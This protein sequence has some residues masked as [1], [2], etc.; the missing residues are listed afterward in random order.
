MQSTLLEAA[1]AY[2]G[3]GLSVIPIRADGSKGPACSA[4]KPYQ[5]RR[6]TAEELPELFAGDVGIGILGGAVSGN[7]E[8]LDFDK[9]GVFEEWRELVEV[10][11]PGLGAVVDALP[12]VSTP[13]D[14]THLYLRCASIEGNLKLAR[15]REPF[16]DCTG[17]SKLELIETR[18]TGG[19]VVAPPSPA[20]CHKANKPYRWVGGAKLTQIP[21][22]TPAQ[23]EAFLKAARYFNEQEEEQPK[24]EKPA[25]AE[26][27]R[28]GL[29]PGDDYNRRASWVDILTGA[30]ATV[31][32]ERGDV[33][34][35]RRPGKTDRGMSAT[36]GKC[37]G[38]S[39]ND[40]LYV[41]S[42]NWPPFEAERTY[43][44]FAAFA[45]LHHGGDF[46]EAARDLGRQGY[47]EPPRAKSN[48]P[49][50]EGN[51]PPPPTDCDCPPW[52]HAENDNAAG[53]EQAAEVTTVSPDAMA[54]VAGTLDRHWHW[55][56]DGGQGWLDHEPAERRYLLRTKLQGTA[57]ISEPVGF[58]PL[59]RVGLGVGSGAAGKSWALAQLGLSVATGCD[60]LGTYEV[61]TPGKVLLVFG[62]EET[63]EVQRRLFYAS[64]LANLGSEQRQRAAGN[65]MA[66][67][68]CG[69]S[70][71]FMYGDADLRLRYRD[72]DTPIPADAR[73]TPFYWELLKRIEASG[74]EWSL[75]VIDPL[76]RFAGPD[77][78]TDNAAATAFVVMLEQLT[79]VPGNPTVLAAHHS[80]KGARQQGATDATAARGSSALVDGARWVANLEGLPR[81][82]G[83]NVPDMVRMRTVKSN[84]AYVPEPLVL[85]RDVTN[86]GA[87]RPATRA[88]IESYERAKKNADGG[89]RPAPRI[90]NSRANP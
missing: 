32:S 86:R 3:A 18:G 2:V 89:E 68:L 58:L 40:L 62:E 41:F 63:A 7:V 22:I 44:K 14:G 80:N 25:Q 71:S 36:T 59:G 11:N 82:E 74:V 65:I 60:W 21:E 34:H 5:E 4:W 27:K 30:G 8:I 46:S 28:D 85:C 50:A 1:R 16:V 57:R 6:P 78:E 75:I 13:S 90:P 29:T 19:Y 12:R 37:T 45:W 38:K 26:V 56:A 42:S 54:A 69:E 47:G 15:A 17:K 72:K 55:L 76:S 24:P 83:A 49:K 88:E 10:V 77:A 81:V 23:R 43:S 39:G 48:A 51:E 67:P 66:L 87:L 33:I 35:W 70:V 52:E 84:Y 9:A 31:A 61:E 20:S 79:K 73:R 64:R 53:E